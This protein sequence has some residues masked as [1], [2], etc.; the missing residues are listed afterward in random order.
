MFGGHEGA[1]IM[2]HAVSPDI[3]TLP[4]ET[5]TKDEA[6]DNL[7]EATI[8]AITLARRMLEGRNLID[9]RR[10]LDDAMWYLDLAKRRLPI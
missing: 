5:M 3:P 8:S 4:P 6:L 2:R 10:K 7:V 1:N 9:A